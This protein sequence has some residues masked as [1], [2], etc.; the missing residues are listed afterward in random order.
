MGESL[1]HIQ[2]ADIAGVLERQGR[3][4]YSLQI[5]LIKEYAVDFLTNKI[6]DLIDC[7]AASIAGSAVISLSISSRGD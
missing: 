1:Y 4:A 2:A 5:R 7:L 6:F 3:G